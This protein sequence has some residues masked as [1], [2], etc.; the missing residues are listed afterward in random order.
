MQTPRRPLWKEIW[1]PRWWPRNGR[2]N[3]KILI[4]AIR[5]NLVPNPNKMWRRQHMN[6]YYYD[7]LASQPFLGHHLGFHIFFHNYLLGAAH[8]FYTWGLDF[9]SFYNCVLHCWHISI[10]NCLLV[11]LFS[12][13][14]FCSGWYM[15]YF[16][17]VSRILLFKFV[18]IVYMPMIAG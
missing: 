16:T 14:F 8:F 18:Y 17:C 10:V 15:Q 3:G 2:L 12:F 7:F 11:F 4:T 1:Y 6:C 5:V 13:V 9:T